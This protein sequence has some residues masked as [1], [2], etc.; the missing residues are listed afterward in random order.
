VKIC[1]LCEQEKEKAY[2]CMK[3]MEG[4]I[5]FG[6]E[7]QLS[8]LPHKCPEC[9]VGIGGFHHLGCGVEQCPKCHGQLLFCLCESGEAYRTLTAEVW[10]T[11]LR[12]ELPDSV[13]TNT[14]R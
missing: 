14:N 5:P 1:D 10:W 8:L 12:R 3:K 13:F 7:S 11:R 9:L 6:E 2:S 4:Q